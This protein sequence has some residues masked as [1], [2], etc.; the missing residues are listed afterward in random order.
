MANNYNYSLVLRGRE[1]RMVTKNLEK[2][3][4]NS[5]VVIQ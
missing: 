5:C 2:I 4:T 3:A 1:T